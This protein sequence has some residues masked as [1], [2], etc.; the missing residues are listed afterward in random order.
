MV[1]CKDTVGVQIK[2]QK[3]V[4]GLKYLCVADEAISWTRAFFSSTLWVQRIF[5][6]CQLIGE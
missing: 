6:R 1:E 2:N 3:G 5:I 4:F